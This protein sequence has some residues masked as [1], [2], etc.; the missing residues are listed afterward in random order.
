MTG[1]G[2]AMP[3]FDGLFD[4]Q[5]TVRPAYFT[6]KLLSRLTGDRLRLVSGHRSVHGLAAHDEKL[7]RSKLLLWN[8]ADTP[9]EVDL[10]LEQMPADLVASPV[11]LDAAAAGDDESVR[12][13]PEAAIELKRGGP[14]FRVGFEP[15]GVRFWSFESRGK[16]PPASP[17]AGRD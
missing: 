16:E 8:F 7:G 17:K 10:I 9:A 11:V 1:G 14:S 4:F 13:R 2:T 3:Q 5:N 15:Y 6:F 12:L